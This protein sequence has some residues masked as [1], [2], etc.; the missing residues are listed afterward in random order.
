MDDGEFRKS[1]NSKRIIVNRLLLFLL[2]MQMCVKAKGIDAVIESMREEGLEKHDISIFLEEK[3]EYIHSRI[4]LK[5]LFTGI[6]HAEKLSKEFINRAKT[7]LGNI[8]GKKLQVRVTKLEKRLNLIYGS[9]ASNGVRN[10]RAIEF[11]G[12]LIS[13]LFGNPGPEEWKQNNRNIVAMKAAIERQLS[14]SILL[15]HDI[16]QN[17]HAINEQNDILKHVTKDVINNENRLEKID[18]ALS[19]FES[20][21]EIESMLNS[22]SSILDALHDI[23]RDAKI[24]RCNEHGLNNQFLIEHL[25]RIESNK[26]GIAPIFASWEWQKYYSFE[27]CTV[28]AHEKEIWITLRIPIVKLTESWTRAIPMSSQK[29]ISQTMLDI[30]LETSLFRNRNSDASMLLT[31]SNLELCSKLGSSRVCNVRKTRFREAEPFLVPVDISHN[32]VLLIMNN[33]KPATVKS[34][35]DGKITNLVIENHAIFKIPNMCSIVSKTFEISKI[36]KDST[37]DFDESLEKIETVEHHVITSN[38]SKLNMLMT[39]HENLSK[40][41]TNFEINNNITRKNL[42]QIKVD[43]KTQSLIFFSTS[44]SLLL[45]IVAGILIALLVKCICKNR[46]SNDQVVVN[47]NDSNRVIPSVANDN[48]NS[49]PNKFLDADCQTTNNSETRKPCDPRLNR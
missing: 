10:R 41:S 11:V 23:K 30:G 35:C 39:Q 12:N 44:G 21:L 48:L 37:I 42:S 18:N 8:L 6:E 45:L 2:L 49:E 31:K 22:I 5:P 29:W 33:S 26:D 38:V 3:V 20:Y 40:L 17:R 28:A 36:P 13:K 7:E 1:T 14:N 25:R 34:I 19:E 27:M 16:D 15:H 4:A 46:N 32:R 43:Q 24:G 9:R 47:F